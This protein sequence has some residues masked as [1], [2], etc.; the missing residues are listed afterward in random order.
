MLIVDCH[1]VAED[2]RDGDSL[3]DWL[4]RLRAAVRDVDLLGRLADARYIVILPQ[5]KRKAADALMQRVRVGLG[6]QSPFSLTVVQ[7]HGA[8]ATDPAGRRAQHPLQIAMNGLV[9]YLTATFDPMTNL[10]FA[11]GFVE[12]MF[13]LDL[14]LVAPVWR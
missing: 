7:I 6:P 12:L 14:R 3:S 2:Q 5:T 1:L 11:K 4:T 8:A 10:G 9:H 13:S